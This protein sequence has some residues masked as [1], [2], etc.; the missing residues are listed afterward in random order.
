MPIVG[1]LTPPDFPVGG[2][3]GQVLVKNSDADFDTTWAA[4]PL[5]PGSVYFSSNWYD[6]RP[7][8]TGA[9]H[10]TLVMTA[11]S[12]WYIPFYL[13]ASITIS[14]VGVYNAAATAGTVNIGFNTPLATAAMPPGSLV[15]GTYASIAVA[16]STGAKTGALAVTLPAGWVYCAIGVTAALTLGATDPLYLATPFGNGTSGPGSVDGQLWAGYAGSSAVPVSSPSVSFSTKE[17][18]AAGPLGYF[19]IA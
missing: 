5:G 11:N 6:L 16:A 1:S 15:G 2:T 7:A 13:P 12:C 19:Q 3:A 17:N 9:V 18:S 10:T 14:N 8:S 4:A